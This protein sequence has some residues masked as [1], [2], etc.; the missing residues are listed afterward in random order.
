AGAAFAGCCRRL[1]PQAAV[2]L[3]DGVAC[4]VA[5]AEV[6]TRLGLP[7]PRAGSYAQ[8]PAR[9]VS[10]VADTVCALFGA[11]KGQP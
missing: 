1:Q 7:K 9:E 10:G 5:L 2:P 11:A 3:L 4:G 8:V 6:L